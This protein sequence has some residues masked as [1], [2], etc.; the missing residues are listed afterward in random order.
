MMSQRDKL[1]EADT[2]LSEVWE[3]MV[4]G[5]V[6]DNAMQE[7]VNVQVMIDRIVWLLNERKN[8]DCRRKAAE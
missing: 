3:E 1:N 4:R 5:K 2:L 7:A 6:E 8:H